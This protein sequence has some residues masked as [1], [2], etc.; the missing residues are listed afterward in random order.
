M[1]KLTHTN[2]CSNMILMG[3]SARSAT[4]VPPPPYT[5]NSMLGQL[6][7]ERMMRTPHVIQHVQITETMEIEVYTKHGL[8]IGSS[9]WPAAIQAAPAIVDLLGKEGDGVDV[10][11]LG[12][13]TGALGVAIAKYTSH[14]VYLSDR[15]CLMD[16]M[17]LNAHLLKQTHPSANIEVKE[18]SWRNDIEMEQSYDYVIGADIVYDP[19][20]FS[21]LVHTIYAALVI[22]G[23][24]VI[25]YTPRKKVAEEQFFIELA[26]GNS[27]TKLVLKE[28]YSVSLHPVRLAWTILFANFLGC[29]NIQVSTCQD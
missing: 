6:H 3:W 20:T 12:A 10:L 19:A 16:I 18:I 7:R 11:E 28:H 23:F 26:K 8:E 21:A 25:A 9:I 5:H 17:R 15:E 1:T 14:K 2:N 27:A 4:L 22:G 13:G 29:A 24:A